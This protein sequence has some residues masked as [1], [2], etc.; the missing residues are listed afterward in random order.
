MGVRYVIVL[1]AAAPGEKIQPAPADVVRTLGEQ[2]DLE[3]IPV[4]VTMHVYRNAAWAPSRA[5][6]PP[7]A[8]DA[9]AINDPFQA[10]IAADLHDAKPA[11]REGDGYAAYAGDVANGD[12][13]HVATASSSRWSMTVDGRTV[14][15]STG[16]G[17]ANEF[18]VDATGR[19]TVRFNTPVQRWLVL[20]LQL[21]LWLGA[22]IVL[23]RLRRRER[24]VDT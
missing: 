4:D 24:T 23:M 21:V 22:V 7:A 8:A 1:E 15:R 20:A 13:V 3:Q 18:A 12:D 19:A 9:V 6:L 11:L 14:P 17:W 2:L 5:L 10:A 16:F